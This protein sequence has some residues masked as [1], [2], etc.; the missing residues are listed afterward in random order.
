MSRKARKNLLR[1]NGY[2]SLNESTVSRLLLMAKH[3][4]AIR[5]WRDTLTQ[6]K[7]D[8]WN[9]PTSI[10]NRCPFVDCGRRRPSQ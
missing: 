7:R 10:C 4:T 1:D 5:I 9:S 6:N 8:S 2:G 3:E